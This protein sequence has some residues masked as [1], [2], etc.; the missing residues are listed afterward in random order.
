MEKRLDIDIEQII[1]NLEAAAHEIKRLEDS[2]NVI[3]AVQLRLTQ[4]EQKDILIRELQNKIESLISENKE[5][6][7]FESPYQI[8]KNR[9]Q[10]EDVSSYYSFWSL[11]QTYV[12]KQE[13]KQEPKK[14]LK[15][16]TKK[17]SKQEKSAQDNMTE[18]RKKEVDEIISQQATKKGKLYDI[19]S[20][21]FKAMT[22]NKEHEKSVNVIQPN[23]M[24][25]YETSLDFLDLQ[26]LDLYSKAI[27]EGNMLSDGTLVF[28]TNK[29]SEWLY[30]NAKPSKKQTNDIKEEIKSLGYKRLQFLTNKDLSEFFGYEMKNDVEQ[31]MQYK[32]PEWKRVDAQFYTVTFIDG[33]K[34]YGQTSKDSCLCFIKFQKDIEKLLLNQIQL[35]TTYS[36]K[37]DKILKYDD[38]GNRVLFRMTVEKIKLRKYLKSFIFSYMRARHDKKI[39]SDKMP[40]D[41]IFERCGIDVK[42]RTQ[43]ERRVEQVHVMLNHYERE[44]LLEF[45]EEYGE[46]KTR[47]YSAQGICITLPEMLYK[48]IIEGEDE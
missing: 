32:L 44:G 4:I 28:S 21:I 48:E 33:Y 26:Y 40:Y 31:L 5:L 38:D 10:K 35:C 13:L 22:N 34:S 12:K 23:D 42:T 18:E 37:F 17:D 25:L 45:W 29:F 47:S 36:E 41:Y 1:D 43:W 9:D 39:Y 30:Q 8:L 7:E 20:P 27:K 15:K 6:K 16:E 19:N 2:G 46:H 14:E 3:G 24:I 11:I